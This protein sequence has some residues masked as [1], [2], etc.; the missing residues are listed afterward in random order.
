MQKV[1]EKKEHCLDKTYKFW[2]NETLRPSSPPPTHL[3]DGKIAR[4]DFSAS[5]SLIQGRGGFFLYF[6]PTNIAAAYGVN[7]SKILK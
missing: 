6:I 1:E 7:G 4:F 5:T 3:N 2:S